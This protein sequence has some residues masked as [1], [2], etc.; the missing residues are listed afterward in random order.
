MSLELQNF[1]YF[2]DTKVLQHLREIEKKINNQHINCSTLKEDFQKFLESKNDNN[3]TS[4]NVNNI[5]YEAF[6]LFELISKNDEKR[7]ATDY[8]RKIIE[9]HAKNIDSIFKRMSHNCDLEN[10]VKN[11]TVSHSNIRSKKFE[12]IMK[13]NVNITRIKNIYKSTHKIIVD[14]NKIL[15]YQVHDNNDKT[16]Q[17]IYMPEHHDVK[18]HPTS[19]SESKEYIKNNPDKV[20]IIDYKHNKN[21]NVYLQT[22]R[23]WINDFNSIENFNPTTVME[24]DYKKY[25]FV[26]NKVNA[27]K[28]NKLVL[29]IS[30][31]EIKL[32][33]KVKY[34]NSV[35][36]KIPTGNYNNV[37]FDIDD[38]EVYGNS[39]GCHP[40][41]Q[42]VSEKMSNMECFCPNESK[43]T[44]L[45]NT[46]DITYI[47]YC[48]DDCRSGYS[49]EGGS[50]WEGCNRSEDDFSFGLCCYKHNY[51]YVWGIY[52][53]DF[54]TKPAGYCK[55]WYVPRSFTWN[56]SEGYLCWNK[57][58]TNLRYCTTSKEFSTDE[59]PSDVC[60]VNTVIANYC[61]PSGASCPPLPPPPPLPYLYFIGPN[62]STITGN[63]LNNQTKYDL[64][65]YTSASRTNIEI[66]YEISDFDS[67][68]KATLTGTILTVN[69]SQNNG[70]CTITAKQG[71][72]GACN[73]DISLYYNCYLE[74]SITFRWTP[75]RP[76]QIKCQEYS[77]DSDRYWDCVEG[78]G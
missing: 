13:G 29:Y 51:V 45:K 62:I 10:F 56:D 26:I 40:F 69:N 19:V 65:E 1:K 18:D 46:F 2:F 74:Y 9:E 48:R 3:T 73:N 15:A 11:H 72:D 60:D 59:T 41:K 39:V 38:F 23:E 4:S 6:K 33:G 5:R 16:T 21:R 78:K 17:I 35:I 24:I 68:T 75:A 52:I 70:Y 44:T 34:S 42:S 58:Q 55:N 14:V 63:M 76:E 57:N 71:N 49:L 37:R 12:Y 8:S 30:T 32:V 25:I 7:E 20:A 53:G 67:N 27:T 31:K 64:N 66:T 43:V 47:D 22:V 54:A 61:C 77:S 36:K 50:C 28:N